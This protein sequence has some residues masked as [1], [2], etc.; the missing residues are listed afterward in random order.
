MRI[1]FIFLLLTLSFPSNAQRHK[2]DSLKNIA[3]QHTDTIGVM[4]FADLCFEYRFI[5]QD[6]AALFGR[7]AIALAKAIHYQ[8][9][10]AQSYS[11]EGVVYYD[12][13]EL[14]SALAYWDSSMV[15]RKM[16]N[17]T[18]G[19]ANL[20]VKKGA[21]YFQLGQFD[22]SL[23]CQL[24]ALRIYE[25]LNIEIGIVQALNNVA[26]VY[27]HQH[28]LDK[29]LA[30]Y[31]R[32]LAIKE[33]MKDPYQIGV[34]LINIGN[35]YLRK[36]QINEAKS[37]QHKAMA[38]LQAA[39]TRAASEYLGMVHNNLADIYT[40]LS[41]YDSAL[42]NIKRALE[43]RKSINDYQGIVSSLNSL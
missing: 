43:I 24:E 39:G 13:K 9:G 19:Q 36:K 28:Q 33:K 42:V 8:K 5:H 31:Q 10:L 38:A 6:S 37:F 22:K 41:K 26:A 1:A 18:Y 15:V 16:E 20:N 17:D 11:D 34:A 2:L 14:L 30:Y 40:Q 32:S 4:A 23:T 35:I 29:A 27:E 25:Q 12:K 3:R 7:Q 21:A